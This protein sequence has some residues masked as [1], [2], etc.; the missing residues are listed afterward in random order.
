MI[1]S[2]AKKFYFLSVDSEFIGKF[3][4]FQGFQVFLLNLQL[5][6]LKNI[7]FF[8]FFFMFNK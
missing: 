7:K 3:I 8:S 6:V 2:K 4:C 1:T 5:I